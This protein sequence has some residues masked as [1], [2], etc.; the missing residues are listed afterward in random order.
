MEVVDLNSL[1]PQKWEP[2]WKTVNEKGLAAL[3]TMNEVTGTKTHFLRIDFAEGHYDL[4]A[5]QYDG[6]TG[7]VTPIIRKMQTYDRAFVARLAGLMIGQDFGIMATFD[8]VNNNKAILRFKASA[9]GPLNKWVKK[10]DVFAVLQIRNSL[11]AGSRPAKDAKSNSAPRPQI[12]TRADN[13]LMQLLSDPKDGICQC[14]MMSRYDDLPPPKG[15]T[16]LIGYRVVKLGTTTAQ[17]KLQLVDAKGVPPK[18]AVHVWI[19][20]DDFPDV[21]N[22]QEMVNHD[23]V[24]ISK[25]PISNAAFTKVVLGDR[26]IARIPIEILDDR[27]VVRT[28]NLQPGAELTA[29]LNLVRA[30]ILNRIRDG[31]IIGN[32]CFQDISAFEQQGGKNQA[33]FDRGQ[34]TMTILDAISGEAEEDIQKLRRESKRSCRAVRH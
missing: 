27:V 14:R 28:I 33:A 32:R 13:V 10:D 7:F 30:E 3:D 2:I 34:S 16:G 21:N 6:T 12:A 4:Q 23:G 18:G 15:V 25:E 24:F 22:H 8:G 5:R 11:Q 9:L 19:R 26:V 31:R 29:R 20:H 17:L 1:A